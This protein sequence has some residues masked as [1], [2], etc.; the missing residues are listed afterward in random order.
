MKI[1]LH[2][3]DFWG[4][5]DGK[6][7]IWI[8]NN[9]GYEVV[10][11][12]QSPDLLIYSV[13][14]RNHERYSCKKVFFTGENVRP[15]TGVWS[16][17]FDF[18]DNPVHVRIPLY[19]YQRW[20]WASE[21]GGLGKN[22]GLD[23]DTIFQPKELT[24]KELLSKKSKFCV[25]M[26]SNGNCEHRNNFF[27]LLNSKKPVTSAG[28]L[29]NNHGSVINWDKKLEFVRDFK[30]MITF[31]NESYPGYTTEKIFEPMLVNTVPIYWGSDTA[32]REFNAKSYIDVNGMSIEDA[33]NLVLEIDADDD[34]YYSMYKEPYL[35]DNR[36]TEW[37]DFRTLENFFRDIL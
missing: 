14:G 19:M 31:E 4:G 34:L 15:P 16:L 23:Y 11:D 27:K 5:F 13:F 24:K 7:F 2:F 25:F 22:L 18:S 1:K 32:S 10:L 8:L 36:I 12:N 29:Y 35:I 20:N 9:I 6:F 26:Q 37:I 21:G 3:E 30:F 28:T 33:V 17:S